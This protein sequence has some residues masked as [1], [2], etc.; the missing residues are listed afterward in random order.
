[1]SDAIEI[2]S[3]SSTSSMST[4]DAQEEK[5]SIDDIV[6]L[7]SDI[8]SSMKN[9]QVEFF[10]DLDGIRGIIHVRKWNNPTRYS[11]MFTY[12]IFRKFH[13]IETSE[14]VSLLSFMTALDEMLQ[15]TFTNKFDT[16]HKNDIFVAWRQY[17]HAIQKVPLCDVMCYVC[18]DDSYDSKLTCGH[19]ICQK[20]IQ[21]S[22]KHVNLTTTTI[23]CG[24]CRKKIIR[25]V[26]HC[27]NIN[28]NH[29]R[30][31]FSEEIIST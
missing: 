15:M 30:C 21:K 24:I 20:C 10:I 31:R 18:L 4:K 14:C 26:A 29:R 8:D 25:K 28:C 22:E 1:M 13:Y 2:S 9:Y 11:A 17:V 5:E 7:L 16:R 6:Q 12:I 27:I 23:V 3:S 19:F